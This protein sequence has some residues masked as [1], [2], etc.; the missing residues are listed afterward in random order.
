MADNLF[1]HRLSSLERAVESIANAVQEIAHN[2]TQIVRLEQQHAATR[3]GLERAFE[4]IT[5]SR[6][7]CEKCSERLRVVEMDMPGLRETRS[8]VLRL[9]L[10]VVGVVGL[11][12]VGLV[13]I[14]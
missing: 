11:A 7:A 5:K 1:E 6:R 13:I 10:G 14:K 3:D 8:W 4:E 9:I 12:V 2:T